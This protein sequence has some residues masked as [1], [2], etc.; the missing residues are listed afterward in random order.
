VFSAE[1]Q[2]AGKSLKC[3]KGG[4]EKEEEAQQEQERKI[5]GVRY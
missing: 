1:R 3:G 2:G 4:A 5:P